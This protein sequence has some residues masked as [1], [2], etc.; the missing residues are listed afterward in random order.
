MI[1]FQSAKTPAPSKSRP[2]A[3]EIERRLATARSLGVRSAAL[4]TP[5]S[6]PLVLRSLDPKRDRARF[7]AISVEPTLFGDMALVRHWGRI[8]TR[9]RHRIDLYPSLHEA[10]RAADAIARSKRRR[11]YR[12]TGMAIDNLRA[13]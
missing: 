4:P 12:E 10:W 1:L 3:R 11:G 6:T 13:W 5:T 9:G 7:Y 8:G 2:S